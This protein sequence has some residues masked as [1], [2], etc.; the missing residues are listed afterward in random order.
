MDY[1]ND[2]TFTDDE[3]SALGEWITKKLTELAGECDSVLCEYV[4]A[5]V[6]NAK[7]MGDINTDLE[8]FIGQPSSVEFA[9][10]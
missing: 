1:L 6:T 9:T 10:R 3:K 8:T 7:T 4:M 2:K 5:M